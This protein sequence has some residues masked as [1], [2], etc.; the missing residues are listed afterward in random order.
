MKKSAVV[1][2]GGILAAMVAGAAA[3]DTSRVLVGR[4]LANTPCD[5]LQRIGFNP[6]VRWSYRLSYAQLMLLGIDTT[7]PLTAV[8]T[9]NGAISSARPRSRT[10]FRNTRSFIR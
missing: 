2:V 3:A 7:E 1:L 6:P 9:S 10:A 5:T 8:Q 4:C